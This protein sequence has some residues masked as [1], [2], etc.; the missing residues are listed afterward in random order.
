MATLIQS[1]A[2]DALVIRSVADLRALR[3]RPRIL[4]ARSLLLDLPGLP[5]E[6]ASAAATNIVKHGNACGCTAGALTM[7]TSLAASICWFAFS[8]GLLT[9]QFFWHLPLIL[10]FA[11]VG[12]G[13]GKLLGIV[14]ARAR[15]RHEIEKIIA[16]QPD[17]ATKRG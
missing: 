5:I 16:S 7:V 14:Y 4:A 8:D 10:V 1:Q 2:Q 17:F 6:T 12:A 3:T 15:L 13:V 9:S 11:F